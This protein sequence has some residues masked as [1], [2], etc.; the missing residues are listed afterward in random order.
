[1]NEELS[2]IYNKALDILSR[3]EH[4]SKELA[5]KLLKKFDNKNLIHE[6]IH[7]LV[8]LSLIHI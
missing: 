8:E 3:R 4:S 5:Q 2:L 7:K 6:A 1:M